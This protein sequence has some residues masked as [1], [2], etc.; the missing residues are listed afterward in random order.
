M[1]ACVAIFWDYSSCPTNKG[2]SDIALSLREGCTKHGNVILFK[3]YFGLPCSVQN[4]QTSTN[5]R[6]ELEEVGVATVDNPKTGFG[7]LA[8]DVF[9]FVLDKY[10]AK[11]TTVVFIS[12][13]PSI[14]YL[15]LGLRARGV[16][17][18]IISPP[19][20]FN[21]LLS[22]ANWTAN[23]DDYGL[24]P[25]P[26]IYTN[27]QVDSKSGSP[28]NPTQAP[29]I[30][31][32]SEYSLVDDASPTR[33]SSNTNVHQATAAPVAP[34]PITY[35]V[36][37]DKVPAPLGPMKYS[38]HTVC[39]SS[40]ELQLLEDHPLYIE[41]VK[42]PEAIQIK[43]W[44]RKLKQLFFYQNIL[45]NPQVPGELD[46]LLT[47]LEEYDKMSGEYLAFTKLGKLLTQISQQILQYCDYR[48]PY[49][50]R[51]RELL[52]KW[53]PLARSFREMNGS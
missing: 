53:E 30:E 26:T 32:D 48:Q 22:Q 9:C 49:A 42:D 41:L 33:D 16:H 14:A 27:Y 2:V 45:K 31:C 39:T 3:A 52:T 34:Q 38:L 18:G 40:H 19:G 6:S 43:T 28:P 47:S 1:S 10:K 8:T 11:G 12:G 46:E 44:R 50:T 5:I 21:K 7:A 17:V 29:G 13:N 36:T 25:G 4:I 15:V 20:Q 37:D 51:A 24:A 35:I 23:G